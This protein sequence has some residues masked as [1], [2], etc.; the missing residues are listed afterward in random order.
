MSGSTAKQKVLDAIKK[1][2]ADATLKTQSSDLSS[3]PRSSGGAPGHRAR[4]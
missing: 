1:L 3:S 2:P 4:E